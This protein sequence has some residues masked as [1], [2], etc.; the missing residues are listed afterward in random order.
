MSKD[1]IDMNTFT[2]SKCGKKFDLNKAELI[3]GELICTDCINTLYTTCKTCGRFIPIKD[4]YCSIC[5]DRI[6]QNAINSYS[7]RPNLNFKNYKLS[8]NNDL[9]NIYYGLEMEYN[10][11]KPLAIRYK[12]DDLY[13]SKLL[14]SKYLFISLNLSIFL[15]SNLLL[16]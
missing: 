15:L 5:N 9:K 4:N 11:V 13:N 14:S 12:L 8:N 3:E 1:Q 10:Y 2:C 7:T 6:Y 16:I